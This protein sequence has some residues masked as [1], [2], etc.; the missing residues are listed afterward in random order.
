MSLSCDAVLG[1]SEAS[2]GAELVSNDIKGVPELVVELEFAVPAC[3]K[4][5]SFRIQ[6]LVAVSAL[7]LEEGWAN[8]WQ[9]KLALKQSGEDGV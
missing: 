1:M 4:V 3:E 8:H 9:A 5:V 6:G 7:G 2:Q